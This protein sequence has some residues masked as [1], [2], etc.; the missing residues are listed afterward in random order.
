MTELFLKEI[1][2]GCFTGFVSAFF[3]IGGS[4]I[5]TPILRTFLG[6]PP[7]LALGTPLP[8]ALL[9]IIVA[10]LTYWK[11]HLVN[12]RVFKL[13][14]LGGFPGIVGGSFLSGFFSG[15]T[16][17]LL[18]AAVLFFVGIYFTGISLKKNKKKKLRQGACEK[19]SP[20]LLL[21]IGA[22]SGFVSGILANG[23]GLFL[24]PSFVIFLR[25]NIKE[26]IATSLAVV[27]VMIL[28]ALFI[29]FN[30][31]HIDPVA[32]LALGIGVLPMAWFG[33]RMDLR[34][35]DSVVQSLF[36]I[37]LVLFSIYFFILQLNS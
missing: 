28:P 33:A 21:G 1:V 18:T 10:L 29:H 6:F 9:T 32:S 34:T 31:G 26:A 17:M 36:G 23:G 14:L 8:T 15:K 22:F 37:V 25:M 24:I 3:G 16:L 27:S 30:L 13:C 7:H 35:R 11:R 12:F 4:S 5:D 20:A 19:A 2:V